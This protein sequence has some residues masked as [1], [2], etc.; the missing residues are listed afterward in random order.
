MS[1]STR[2]LYSLRP[3]KSR[4][5]TGFRCAKSSTWSM[6]GNYL[7]SN[8][9]AAVF[10]STSKTAIERCENYRRTEV[11]EP[12]QISQGSRGGR[13]A[14]LFNGPIRSPHDGWGQFQVL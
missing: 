7:R 1:R 6:T 14:L 9:V 5:V 12:V 10:D 4:S 13:A 3:K 11:Y 2:D 8:L